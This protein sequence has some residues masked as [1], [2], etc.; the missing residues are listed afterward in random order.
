MTLII[1]NFGLQCIESSPSFRL[2][3]IAVMRNEILAISTDAPVVRTNTGASAAKSKDRWANHA[4]ALK[5]FAQCLIF[6]LQRLR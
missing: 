2:G 6:L 4:A 3:Q 5:L 1:V